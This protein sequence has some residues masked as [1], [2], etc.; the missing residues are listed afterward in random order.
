MKKTTTDTACSPEQLL[1]LKKHKRHLMLVHCSRAMFLIL[2]LLLWEIS[3]RAGYINAFIFSSPS[4]IVT[5]G[6]GLLKSGILARHMAITLSETFLSFFLVSGISLF[7]AVL[8]WWNRTLCEILEPYMVILNSL[9]K[10]AMAPIFIV[11][12]GNNE[13]TIIVSAISVALFGSILNLF[14]CFTSTDPDKLKLIRTLGGNR[15]DC[16]AKVVIPINLPSV[17]SIMK[18]DIGLCLIGVIIGEF[19]AAKEGLGY[20][21]IYG[22]QVLQMECF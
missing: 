20:L 7:F 18:V 6:A 19:L 8:L 16:L 3:A 4:R 13:K 17:L 11:W 12:L 10:S 5:C 15:L 1:F 2:W 22:A 9:P 21:I 14:T